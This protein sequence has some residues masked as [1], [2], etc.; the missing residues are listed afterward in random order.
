M[1]MAVV[2]VMAIWMCIQCKDDDIKLELYRPCIQYPLY[3]FIR[4]ILWTLCM[5]CTILFANKASVM[6]LLLLLR[7]SFV[8]FLRSQFS[9]SAE[10]THF[11]SS[12]SSQRTS[13][14]IYSATIEQ[15]EHAVL[16]RFTVHTRY[17]LKTLWWISN[18]RSI[19]IPSSIVGIYVIS[20]LSF[21]LNIHLYSGWSIFGSCFYV[22][23]KDILVR[24]SHSNQSKSTAGP[25][26]RNELQI[27]RVLFHSLLL[28]L[29]GGCERPS[30]FTV[31]TSRFQ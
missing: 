15:R 17:A 25:E 5:C 27:F 2:V 12:S 13:I 23:S 1:L 28:L 21:A 22:E 8:Y 20:C 16:A 26:T 30:G 7:L 18:G 10:S 29:V 3:T 14:K 4:T 6:C 11:R 24:S 19:T 9:H 31:H